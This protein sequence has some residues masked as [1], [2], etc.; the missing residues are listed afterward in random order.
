MWVAVND[1]KQVSFGVEHPKGNYYQVCN[2]PDNSINIKTWLEEQKMDP[3]MP[4]QFR[5]TVR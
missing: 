5:N 4:L 2:G 3:A 1:T